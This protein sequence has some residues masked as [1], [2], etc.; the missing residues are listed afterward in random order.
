MKKSQL[1]LT[2]IFMLTLVS[3]STIVRA[4]VPA[5]PSD[6]TKA[7]PT[8]ITDVSKIY[9][10][11]STISLTGPL[12][13]STGNPF[14]KY[15]WYKLA[16]DQTTKTEETTQTSQTYTEVSTTTPGYYYYELVTE[17]ANGC[18][19]PISS[20]LQVYVLPPLSVTIS[21]TAVSVCQNS[22]TT[23]V[24]TANPTPVPPAYTLHYQWTKTIG[25]GTTTNVG[26]DSPTYPVPAADDVTPEIITYAV[27]VTYD[28]N[29]ACSAAANQ[30][31]TI[32]A[33]PTQPTIT[34]N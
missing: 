4:Q 25:A 28:L 31:I 19:S 26:S 14:T 22:T 11:G 5:G 33:T 15:H 18:T 21:T 30:N 6:A 29:P 27:T 8:S 9:C 13:P 34:A 16:A 12:D 20:L 2:I 32:F 23:P 24:L 10:A 3:F 1:L 7:A 17:N